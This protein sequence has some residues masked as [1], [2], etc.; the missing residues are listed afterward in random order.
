MNEL[1]V[2]F[3]RAS[4]KWSYRLAPSWSQA[5]KAR[6][7]ELF[8]TEEDFADLRWYLEEYMV[9]PDAGGLVRATR[10]ER[11]LERW[12]AKLHAQLFEAGDH[13]ELLN[14]LLDGEAPRLLTVATQEAELLRVPWELVRNK[15][16]PLAMQGVTI[17]RQLENAGRAAK[18]DPGK[19]PLRILLVVSRPEDTG[20]IEARWTTRSMLDALGPLGAGVEVDFCRPATFARM[21]EMLAAATRR[22]APYHI[23]HF[24]GHG[25]Y[26]RALQLGALCF[27]KDESQGLTV[28]ADLVRADR[29]GDLLAGHKVPLAILEACQSAEIGALSAFRSVAPRLIEAGVGSVVAMSYAVHVEAA[30]VLMARFYAV[31]SEGSTIGEAMEAG[32]GAL[33]A[34]PDRWLE[35][36]PM[37]DT[38]ALQDWFL[39]NLY[40]KGE[41]LRL[42]PAKV[43]KK[44]AEKK[45][46]GKEPGG[47]P[48]APV[49][50]F[51]GREKELHKLERVFQ[52][53]R[54]VLLHAMGGM[55]KTSLSREAAY[56]WTRTGLFPDGACFVSFEQGGGADRAVQVLG[57]Y[58][59]GPEFERLPGEEQKARA[60]EIFRTKKVLVVWDN[61]ESVLPA[62]NKEGGAA[63]YPDEER[64][65][66][67]GLFEE[68]TREDGKGR[69]LVTCRPGETGLVGVQKTE[70]RGLAR[71]DALGLLVQVM[72]TAGVEVGDKKVAREGLEKLLE[73]VGDHPLSIELVGPHL[74]EMAAEKI[75]EDFQG[76]LGKFK[77]DA[78]EGRNRSLL[79]SLEFSTRRLGK[80]AREAL[81]WLGWFRG[82]VFEQVVLLISKMDPAVWEVARTEMEATALVRVEGDMQM[83]DR[84]YLRF[85]P[86]LAYA[87]T[88]GE[89]PPAIRERF[90]EVY[91][92]VMG[93]AHQGLFG[94]NPRGGMDVIEREEAN[95]RAAVAWALGQGAH[96]KASNMGDT[97]REYLQRSGR[98]RERDRWVS[99]LAGEVRK[100]GFSKAMADREMDEA[101]SLLTQGHPR[102]ALAKLEAL[103]A[104]LETTN[105]FDAA[106]VLANAR[107]D[108]GRA[109]NAV[110]WAQKAI[111]VLQKAVKEWEAL[112][113]KARTRGKGAVSE[114]GNLS[115]TLGDLA[116]AY[117]SA[118]QLGERWRPQSKASRSIASLGTTAMLPLGWADRRRFSCIKAGMRK[119]TPGMTKRSRRRS[120]LETRSLWGRCS[121]I[122][123]VW[124]S[125]DSKLTAQPSSTSARFRS[126]RRSTMKK[127][128]CKPATSWAWWSRRLAGSP[129][130]APGMSVPASWPSGVGIE[131]LWGSPRRT[132]ASFASW[133]GRPP[134]RLGIRTEQER[135]LWKQHG[136]WRKASAFGKKRSISPMRQDLTTNSV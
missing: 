108:L 64:S 102:E 56:W 68:W 71:A 10:I 31:L 75:V 44:F 136:S 134:R 65:K 36:G 122:R 46:G 112:V 62:F 27:E 126:C 63:L 61:F 45:A 80:E 34:S 72:K 98:L 99:W 125:S 18:F 87:V 55:G 106:F 57:A 101:W 120:V 26:L 92:A 110:G 67:L 89:R 48:R 19:L 84:P 35:R 77:G 13:R 118:G 8:L 24:D 133:K 100:G 23:V 4:D 114:R 96:D 54:A 88:E 40:Q 42:V 135:A 6:D 50:K 131:S 59:D 5:T 97:I 9:L 15:K 82:G 37:G 81:G 94:S 28:K 91:Y 130:R 3:E 7:F 20:F 103:V 47:F 83:N 90:V 129:R 60:R 73:A 113:D 119:R 14:D 38:V 85:H 121:S 12:G 33:L 1:R 104:R 49:H 25:T 43:G 124:P 107:S 132:L 78:E 21:N 2:L 41:D 53:H 32:R 123:A 52:G 128:S 16:G 109:Y 93:A 39:P 51:H 66:V 127:G 76:L 95:L 30:K 11:N 79:A 29:I 111:P 22:G 74:K 58:V 115:A 17:R 70:L 117:R 86:T 116:N 105:D 69:L